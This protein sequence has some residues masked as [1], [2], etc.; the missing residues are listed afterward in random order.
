MWH[1]K[2]SVEFAGDDIS[3][4]AD[5]L[6][7]ALQRAPYQTM[8]TA[9]HQKYLSRLIIQAVQEV[10][11]Q[12]AIK[13]WD[14]CSDILRCTDLFPHGTD[15][16]VE[17]I[18]AVLGCMPK[19]SKVCAKNFELL[20]DTAIGMPY[21]LYDRLALGSSEGDLSTCGSSLVMAAIVLRFQKLKS[22]QEA[23]KISEEDSVFY[24]FLKR[25]LL[26]A[27]AC[28]TFM[29]TTTFVDGYLARTLPTIMKSEELWWTVGDSPSTQICLS[30]DLSKVFKTTH[31]LLHERGTYPFTTFL[32]SVSETMR[33]HDAVFWSRG[34]AIQNSWT[35]LM[36]GEAWNTRVERDRASS[37]RKD[38]FS[39]QATESDRTSLVDD[40]LSSLPKLVFNYPRHLP[41]NKTADHLPKEPWRG[42][43]RHCSL[44]PSSEKLQW[45]S[46][47]R[48]DGLYFGEDE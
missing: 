32:K 39:F 6:E 29:R 35:S 45:V 34:R 40:I 44:H 1:L 28:E 23:G 21:G 42:R 2:S 31:R 11:E 25:V 20:V 37:L 38:S 15:H 36:A 19:S 8:R 22:K 13:L 43:L 16:E 10:R 30:K 9:I 26:S 14:L 18:L 48:T 41:A 7:S 17:I 46:V 4:A 27:S 3:L 33:L 47:V 24:F 12:T 5:A